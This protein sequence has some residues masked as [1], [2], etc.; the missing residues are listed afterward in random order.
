MDYREKRKAEYPEIGEQLDMLWHM[1][2]DYGSADKEVDSTD[3]NSGEVGQVL[4]TWY[5]TIKDIKD[6]YPKPEE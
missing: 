1:L 6:K 5:E 2:N 4:N 3:E